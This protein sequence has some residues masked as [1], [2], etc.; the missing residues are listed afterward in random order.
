VNLSSAAHGSYSDAAYDG[1]VGNGLL[2]RF[3]VTFHYGRGTMYLR[4]IA[5][6][7][8]DVGRVDRIGMW[9][10]LDGQ[11]LKVTDVVAGGPAEQAGL[12]IGDVVTMIDGTSFE[13]RSLSDTRRALKLA[14]LTKPLE[15][16]YRRKGTEAVALVRP[17]N[18]IPD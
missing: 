1:N 15:I 8:V 14:S 9:I 18:L 13:Q 5:K 4:P 2:K 12:R 10:N 7:D 17:R 11:G 16:R 6:P 3:V